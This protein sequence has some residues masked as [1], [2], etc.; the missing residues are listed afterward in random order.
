[1]EQ[2]EL[3]RAKKD[4]VIKRLAGLRAI[5][6]KLED[7]G[8]DVHD[9]IS[10]IGKAIMDVEDDILRV[11][12]IG[13]FADG[14]TSVIAGWLGRVMSNMKIDLDESSDELTIY[15]PDDLPEKCEIIDTPGLFG[16]KTKYADNTENEVIQYGDITKKY[17]S[18]AHLILYV[19]DATNPLKDS[20][21]DEIE[22][23]LR[24]L[25]KLSST[26]FVINKMDEVADL[27]DSNDFS[28]QSR[29]KKENLLKKLTRF[30]DLSIDEISQ[31]QTVC[32]A[33]NPQNRGL[34]YWLD[35]KETYEERSRIGELR[36]M[37]NT[38][39]G[40]TCK[41]FLITKTGLDVLNDIIR[42]KIAAANNEYAKLDLFVEAISTEIQRIEQDIAKG[43]ASIISAKTDLEQELIDMENQ[44][45]GRIRLLSAKDIVAFLED[46]IG[47]SKDDVGYKLRLRIENAYERC[48]QR[49]TDAINGIRSSI[50]KEL[51]SSDNFIESISSSALIATGK[52]LRNVNQLPIGTIKDA[53]FAARDTIAKLTGVVMKFKPWQ[54]EKLAAIISKYAGPIGAGIQVL[55]DLTEMVMQHKVENKL[56]ETRSQ[57][58]E[59][60]KEHFKHVYDILADHRKVL[61]VFAPQIA[62]FE[63]I[64]LNQKT[65]LQKLMEKRGEL[66]SIKKQ[67]ESNQLS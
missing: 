42:N 13:A 6:V 40:E 45:N 51:E 18:E 30:L 47:Y 61:E 32:V 33:S 26:V 38:I 63:E 44:L 14:K 37:T 15:H 7:I 22:W 10:K 4:E 41:A 5:V 25:N 24:K 19:V 34:D 48:F 54:A 49:F 46:E 3:Y 39:L 11:A 56:K 9:D 65:S 28:N 55:A 21:K 64:L 20:H 31:I 27:R 17:L 58:K 59:M 23:I 2:F 8:L 67:F 66:E 62:S 1:M 53:V 60:V 36:K 43:T 35:K 52:V 29:I 12:L 57:I 16:S 50:E